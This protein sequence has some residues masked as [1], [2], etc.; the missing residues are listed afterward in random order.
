MK[1]TAEKCLKVGFIL[2]AL[3]MLWLLFG[4]R[5]GMDSFLPYGEK[6]LSRLNLI[7]L[8]TLSAYWKVLFHS[9]NPTQIRH[10]FIN[11]GGNIV[12]F[13]PLGFFLPAIF[14]KLRSF[15]RFFITVV[16]LIVT[17][18]V[19]QLFT[20]L[21]SCDVDDLLLNLPGATIGFGLWKLTPWAKKQN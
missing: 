13:I 2:Y 20:L 17:I 3:V 16:L 9:A 7:P 8:K 10:A 1:R 5:W 18:E 15:W 14:E 4:Q 19:L 6:I 21:G 11:L 12:T